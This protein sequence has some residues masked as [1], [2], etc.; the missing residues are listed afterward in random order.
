MYTDLTDIL[1]HGDYVDFI[2]AISTYYEKSNLEIKLYNWT[3]HNHNREVGYVYADA[4]YKISCKRCFK[5]PQLCRHFAMNMELL[6]RDYLER[7]KF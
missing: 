1:K 6:F 3:Y 4:F 2:L 5:R 7:E